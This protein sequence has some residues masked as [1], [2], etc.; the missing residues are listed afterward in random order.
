MGNEFCK[1]IFLVLLQLLIDKSIFITDID[2][3]NRWLLVLW[4]IFPGLCLR[5]LMFALSLG[6]GVR[7]PTSLRNEPLTAKWSFSPGQRFQLGEVVEIYSNTISLESIFLLGACCILQ[8]F[9]LILPRTQEKPVTIMTYI[10]IINFP[11][12][13]PHCSRKEMSTL[14]VAFLLNA[15]LCWQTQLSLLDCSC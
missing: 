15:K 11:D 2:L 4:A 14:S 10:S 1:L 9:S 3:E 13:C 8:T 7:F 12:R 6:L 5:N